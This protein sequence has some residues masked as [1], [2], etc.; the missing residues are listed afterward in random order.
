LATSWREILSY[1]LA[2]PASQQNAPHG[3]KAEKRRF[4]PLPTKL[5]HAHRQRIAAI[6]QPRIFPIALRALRV[7][8]LR[9]ALR[10]RRNERAFIDL[11]KS[12]LQRRTP[13]ERALRPGKLRRRARLRARS[14][15]KPWRKRQNPAKIA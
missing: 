6:Q 15:T 5:L 2:T 12:A 9:R 14:R 3:V 1:R 8:V 11:R 7:G 4:V 13:R 10:R